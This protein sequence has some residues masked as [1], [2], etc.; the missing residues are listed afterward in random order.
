MLLPLLLCRALPAQTS[1]PLVIRDVTVIDGTGAKPQPGMTVVIR[2]GK[3]LE[4]G[5][6]ARVKLD[7]SARVIDGTG[8][9]LI[10]GLW[11]MHGHLTDAGEGSLALLIENG[12]TGV[13]DL[14]GDLELVQRWRREIQEGKR[15][16]PHILA[17]GPL[18]DGPTKSQWHVV[19]NNDAE[20]RAMVRSIR[21][22]GADFLKIHT[23]I[24]REAFYA[25][26][27]EAKKLGMPVA[28]HLPQALTTAEASDAGVNSLEHVEMLVQSALMQQDSATK[29]KSDDE[30][31]AAALESLTGDN[32]AAL[33]ARL[34]K[35]HTWY[36]PTM[37]AYER[38]FVLWYNKPIAMS[39]R[40]PVHWKQIDIVGAMHKAGVKVLAGSD[41]SDWAGIPGVDLHNELALLA[42]A[43]FSPMEALQSATSL[44]AEFLGKTKD[45]GTVEVGKVADLVLLD[46]DPMED[47]S[48]TRKIRA[49]ILGGKYLD[50]VKMRD[51][52]FLR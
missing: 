8:K 14:G 45:Y 38:G 22:R 27:D 46:A 52:M 2:N 34:V 48:H 17:A 18:L 25:A 30:R 10:P 35:N 9:F 39:K 7:H 23:R 11:D 42:E 3:I 37:V 47:I 13:R 51:A 36:D 5:Q 15:I 29:K 20:A 33:W 21:Q 50:I 16:G 1:T 41:F 31:F 32:G 19:V 44:P 49:V 40:R 24:S 28:V 4:I 6:A 43:G 26:V 12:V